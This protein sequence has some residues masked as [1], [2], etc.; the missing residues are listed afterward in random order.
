MYAEKDQ[1]L[2]MCKTG[3]AKKGLVLNYGC[4]IMPTA[5]FS[6]GSILSNIFQESI[7]LEANRLEPKSGPTCV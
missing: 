5:L 1:I 7:V 4:I 6:K 3:L 2:Y